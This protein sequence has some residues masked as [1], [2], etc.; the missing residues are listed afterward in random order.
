MK[1]PS[2]F[3]WGIRFYLSP[4]YFE[5]LSTLFW[6]FTTVHT[7]QYCHQHSHMYMRESMTQIHLRSCPNHLILRFPKCNSIGRLILLHMH[8]YTNI[9]HSDCHGP[10]MKLAESKTW[11]INAIPNGYVDSQGSKIFTCCM[12]FFFSQKKNSF[13]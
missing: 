1:D 7:H 8:S 4:H 10:R 13:H 6:K 12:V 11:C 2:N 3:L 9:L 5:N